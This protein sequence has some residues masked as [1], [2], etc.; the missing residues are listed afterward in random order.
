MCLLQKPMLFMVAL[1]MT[2]LYSIKSSQLIVPCVSSISH[3]ALQKPFDYK[4]KKWF[5]QECYSILIT[6]MKVRL[7]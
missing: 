5:N 7:K 4:V 2:M 1:N 6:L 3:H